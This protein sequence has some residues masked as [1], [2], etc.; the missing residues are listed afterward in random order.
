VNTPFSG[1]LLV[2]GDVAFEQIY[3]AISPRGNVLY[4]LILR[5]YFNSLLQWPM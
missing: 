5:E 2:M 1:V 4:R 3:N